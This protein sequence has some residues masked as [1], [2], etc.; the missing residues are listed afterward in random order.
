MTVLSGLITTAPWAAGV[1]PVTAGVPS[2]VS[3]ASTA[4]ITA[5]SSAVLSVSSTMSATGPTVTV[6]VAVSVTPADMVV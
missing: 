4:M 3:L 2:N 1:T 5:V 6:T